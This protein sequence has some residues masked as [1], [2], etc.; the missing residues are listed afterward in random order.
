MAGAEEVMPW[1]RALKR[2]SAVPTADVRVRR[3]MGGNIQF[4]DALECDAPR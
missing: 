1:R 3:G 2:A 4:R